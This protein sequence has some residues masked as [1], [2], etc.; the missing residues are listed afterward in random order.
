M[1]RS[2]LPL[3]LF[4]LISTIVYN[5]VHTTLNDNVVVYSKFSLG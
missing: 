1:D 2:V 5:Y 4:L 3:I